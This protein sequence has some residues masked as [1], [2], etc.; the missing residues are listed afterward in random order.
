MEG[1]GWEM[2]KMGLGWVGW[3]WVRR[4]GVRRVQNQKKKWWSQASGLGPPVQGQVLG[5]LVYGWVGEG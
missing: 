1:A 3:V 4:L 5:L 2:P